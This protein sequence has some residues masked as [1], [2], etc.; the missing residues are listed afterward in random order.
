[1][2]HLFRNHRSGDHAGILHEHGLFD[3]A[4]LGMVAQPLE[5]H[6]RQLVACSHENE[7]LWRDDIRHGHLTGHQLQDGKRA[8][9]LPYC[10]ECR[11]IPTRRG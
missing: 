11:C 1:M 8:H 10:S 3:I 9:R 7:P 4:Q 5:R 2:T 6:L